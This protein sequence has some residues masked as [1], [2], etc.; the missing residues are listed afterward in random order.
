M[1][2]QQDETPADESATKSARME[3]P[4]ELSERI[5]EA[6]AFLPLERLALSP[7]CGFST[8]IMGNNITPEVQRQKLMTVVETAGRVW[9]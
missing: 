8:S 5:A 6:A 1:C 9:A 3:S 4:E 2:R 7:Q